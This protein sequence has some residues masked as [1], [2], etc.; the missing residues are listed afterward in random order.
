MWTDVG[1]VDPT[2][3]VGGPDAGQFRVRVVSGSATSD[4]PTLQLSF[5]PTTPG[6]KRAWAVVERGDARD[7]HCLVGTAVVA[8]A[9][10]NGGG[11]GDGTGPNGRATGGAAAGDGASGGGKVT[12]AVRGFGREFVGSVSRGV[13]SVV[14]LEFARDA[15]V[16]AGAAWAA[17][18]GLVGKLLGVAGYT[19]SGVDPTAGVRKGIPAALTAWRAGDF[20]GVGRAL[21]G[22]VESVVFT[23]AAAA[24]AWEGSKRA[25][26]FT[27]DR[28]EAGVDSRGSET[29]SMDTYRDFSVGLD[30]AFSSGFK[31]TSHE[32]IES[33]RLGVESEPGDEG[34][35]G[36]DGTDGKTTGG[37]PGSIGSSSTADAGPATGGDGTDRD[38]RR[39]LA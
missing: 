1:G 27:Q 25:R 10:R 35:D 15:A 39:E 8:G 20:E 4:D 13:V 5:A 19:L 22:V 30:A 28:R 32:E 9:S 29:P 38:D 26:Q 33:E 31:R 34:A 11:A 2:V 36:M 21:F 16:G 17:G 12:D 18:D 7:V 6:A 3:T 37:E 14:T 23:G 24:G